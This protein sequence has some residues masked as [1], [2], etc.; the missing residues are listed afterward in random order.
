MSLWLLLVSI[1]ALVAIAFAGVFFL[2]GPERIWA[3]FGPADLGPVQFESLR[4]SGK[5]KD[6][7]AGPLDLTTAEIDLVPPVYPIDA[8]ALR[9]AFVQAISTE[10][11]LTLVDIDDA[12][13]TQR[14]VQRTEKMRFPDT[15]VVRFLELPEG[16]ST[17][18]MYSRSQIGANDLGVN[19][20]RLERWLD[21]LDREVAA[22]RQ[23]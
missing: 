1:V 7:L 11:R 10:R 5:P 18:A 21:K 17:I 20:A 19:R 13:A 2:L 15:I 14:F 22:D 3:L 4:R 12:R 8:S 9:R 6:A 16:R 23:R